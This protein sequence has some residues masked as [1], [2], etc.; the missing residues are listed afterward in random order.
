MV[1]ALLIGAL[2]GLLSGYGVGGGTLLLLYLTA[3]AGVP[4]AM[5]QG[6][7]LVYFLPCSAA[8]LWSHIKNGMVEK[9][10]LLTAI[11]AGCLCTLPAAWLATAIDGAVLSRIFGSFLILVGLRELFSAK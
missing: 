4:Q 5:A 6:V 9:R 10:V 2:T 11:L 8:A 1:L 3:V 7:N